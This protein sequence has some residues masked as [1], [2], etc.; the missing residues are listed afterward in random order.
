MAQHAGLR[1][2]VRARTVQNRIL[3]R[4]KSLSFTAFLLQALAAAASPSPRV[5]VNRP[6]QRT[7]GGM[8]PGQ[9]GGRGGRCWCR[10]GG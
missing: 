2:T 8:Q 6:C 5:I 10:A 1:S 9:G 3:Y 4:L 7:R